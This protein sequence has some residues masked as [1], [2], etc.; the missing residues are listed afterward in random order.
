MKRILSWWLLA[1]EFCAR[2]T[3]PK[4]DIETVDR[5]IEAILRASWLWSRGE[6]FVH[7]V[8]AAWLDSRCRR[9]IRSPASHES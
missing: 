3:A 2:V 1:E 5:E 8:H 4:T 9:L 6:S 7:K